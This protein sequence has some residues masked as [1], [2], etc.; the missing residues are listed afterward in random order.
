MTARILHVDA[1]GLDFAY[2]EEGKGPL[3][4]LVHGFPDTAYSWDHTRTAVAAAGFRAVS[5]F[6]RGYWPT[7][8]PANGKYDSET[9]GSDLLALIEA[10]GETSAIL[11]GHDW[12]A[13]AVF[14]A[15]QIDPAKVRFLV[16]VGI[17]HPASVRPS[18]GLVWGARHMIRFKLP[19][20]LRVLTEDDS[21][22]VDELV[23]R[24]S[25]TWDF[26]AKETAPI[27][28]AFRHPGCADATLGYYRAMTPIVN[29]VLK[30]QI[31]VPALAFSGTDDPNL[32]VDD[33]ERARK[34][35]T[36]SYDIVSMPGGH[37][38]H[39]E[40]PERFTSDLV[41]ALSKLP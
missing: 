33:Y 19:G 20:A 29:D 35:Y 34:L 38:M 13:A 5:P 6:T 36:S 32:N 40:H 27:K 26:D 15:T 17:P 31:S 10:L 4:L 14:A 11:V 37:F 22:H 7:A 21:A 8:I 3:V 28:E 24:W 16:T 12:G 18:L 9:L 25:P 2:L 30:R 23:K 1:N 41:A 39:R